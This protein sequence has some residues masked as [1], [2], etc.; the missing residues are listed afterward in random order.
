MQNLNLEGWNSQVHRAFAGSFLLYVADLFVPV[1]PDPSAEED[2]EVEHA[3]DERHG[4]LVDRLQ[5]AGDRDGLTALSLS[6]DGKCYSS[7]DSSI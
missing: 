7:G 3:Y 6:H 5:D 2:W 1:Q 4:G